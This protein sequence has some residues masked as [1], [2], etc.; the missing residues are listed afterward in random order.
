MERSGWL[1]AC[2]DSINAML[3]NFYRLCGVSTPGIR[4]I[5]A[6]VPWMV[7]TGPEPVKTRI[8]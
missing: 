5:A 6:T 4:L 3:V 7:S 2:T 1:L 8:I